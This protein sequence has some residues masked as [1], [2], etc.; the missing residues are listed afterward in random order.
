MSL[1]FGAELRRRRLHA[2]ISL[3]RFAASVHYS[4]SH[5]SK[6][7]LGVKAPSEEFARRCDA[8]L[9]AGGAL[10]KLVAALAP[11]GPTRP[12][13]E[14]AKAAAQGP[15]VGPGASGSRWMIE[16][17]ADGRGQFG[18]VPHRGMLL[19]GALGALGWAMSPAVAHRAQ[20]DSEFDV[21]RSIFD[22]N[23]RLG[24]TVGPAA[25]L[26][27]L[28]SQTH[29]LRVMAGV[30][31]AQ[32]RARLF[33]LAGRFA[34]FTGWIAQEAGDDVGALWWTGVAVELA[35]T[36]GDRELSAYALLRRADIA[37]Y[38]R[39]AATTVALA[40]RVRT[41]SQS[42]RVCGLAAQREAQGYALAGDYNGC[43]RAL[44]L[45][46]RWFDQPEE[47]DQLPVLG[48]S[49][50]DDPVGMASG[51]CLFDLGRP[52]QASEQLGVQL[53]KI[54]PHVHRMRARLGTRCV[55]AFVAAGELDAGCREIPW[56]LD[57][58]LRAHSAT[59]GAELRR[60]ARLLNRWAS[61]PC[62]REVMPD[63][64]AALSPR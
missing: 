28:I 41:V 38:Q 24:Q 47:N 36:G 58:F 63:L 14:T 61:Q 16:L 40:R 27:V 42:R 59:V 20:A 60:L 29:A 46:A 62:V 17:S 34:E 15:A 50:I 54:P 2:G 31:T 23:R 25:L 18:T 55:L 4:K 64:T 57:S 53:A 56:V 39:D 8:A 9:T 49:N 19:T 5:V 21:F 35:E 51:W 3:G 13:G 11:A 48:S 22:D 10:A 43:H 45:A 26:P 52:K 12:P 7:E 1:S 32:Q 37:L 33:V 6:V 44:D 30:T